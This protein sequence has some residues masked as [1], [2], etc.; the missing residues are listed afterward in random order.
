MK[1][2]LESL[3]V[4]FLA[5]TVTVASWGLQ[6][7]FLAGRIHYG[8]PVLSSADV[9]RLERSGNTVL[10]VTV[11][12]GD[13][14]EAREHVLRLDSWESDLSHLLEAWNPDE[15]VIVTGDPKSREATRKAAERLDRAGL[16]SVYLLA[17]RD[18]R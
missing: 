12:T 10:W 14:S 17:W 6:A 3:V 16:P 4:V 1:V 18:T 13:S 11:Q 5:A 7:K 15:I 2:L 9:E 8:V